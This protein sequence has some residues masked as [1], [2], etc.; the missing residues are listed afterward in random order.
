MR[1][2]LNQDY[3]SLIEMGLQAN[4]DCPYDGYS[5]GT[6]GFFF[7]HTTQRKSWGDWWSTC[8][9]DVE[10][11]LAEVSRQQLESPNG[12]DETAAVAVTAAMASEGGLTTEA[13]LAHTQLL[14]RYLFGAC[15]RCVGK[16]EPYDKEA[17][18]LLRRAAF[19][20]AELLEIREAE[21]LHGEAAAAGGAA[22]QGARRSEGGGGNTNTA[23]GKTRSPRG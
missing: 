11:A 20:E 4:L 13:Q 10:A 3:K 7:W 2:T 5:G 14:Y 21:G 1:T 23:C 18:G 6:I 16:S 12:V 19:V 17:D 8:P 9:K 22:R 15:E